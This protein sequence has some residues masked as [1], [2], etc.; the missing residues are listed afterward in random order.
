M[1]KEY[2]LYNIKEYE[3][4]VFLGTLKEIAKYLDYNVGSLRSYLTRKKSGGQ[5][6]YNINMN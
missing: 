6:I 1:I 4:L 2:G 3:Q 5:N